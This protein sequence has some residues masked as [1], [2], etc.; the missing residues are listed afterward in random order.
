MAKQARQQVDE[1]TV[2]VLV[3][4]FNKLDLSQLDVTP[5]NRKRSPVSDTSSVDM[6]EDDAT[7]FIV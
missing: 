7:A 4:F 5:V 2:A 1:D 6:T 3:S